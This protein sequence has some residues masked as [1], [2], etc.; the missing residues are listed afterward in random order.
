MIYIIT[1]ILFTVISSVK[2]ITVFIYVIKQ[3]FVTGGIIHIHITVNFMIGEKK[4][5]GNSISFQSLKN[6]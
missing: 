6:P 3:R 5:N 4:P 2:G 1:K